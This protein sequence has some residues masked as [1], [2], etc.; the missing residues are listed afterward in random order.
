MYRFLL[1]I[2]DLGDRN[3]FCFKF[4]SSCSSLW[5][6]LLVLVSGELR[7]SRSRCSNRAGHCML[8]QV[9]GAPSKFAVPA[10]RKLIF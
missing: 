4:F 7:F 8:E 3:F 9:L 5:N 1:T 6:A 2:L 10:M